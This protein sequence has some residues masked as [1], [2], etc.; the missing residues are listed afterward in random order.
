MSSSHSQTQSPS[1]LASE[2]TPLLTEDD[3]DQ[4]QEAHVETPR[5]FQNE[6]NDDGWSKGQNTWNLVVLF[7]VALTIQMGMRVIVI[8]LGRIIES[9]VCYEYWK[10]HDPEDI[11]L[12]G[13]IQE[14]M[15]KIVDVQASFATVQGYYLLLDSL[16]S[17]QFMLSIESY[18]TL[19]L[20]RRFLLNTLWF[21]D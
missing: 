6:F 15:C 8:P 14:R 2:S 19:T 13:E 12:S 18:S 3:R 9:A 10:Q 7:G 20:Y 1:Q 16:F 5:H 21:I 4:I 11:P 17:E